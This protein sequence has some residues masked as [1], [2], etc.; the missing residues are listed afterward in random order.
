[1]EQLPMFGLEITQTGKDSRV[2]GHKQT[3]RRQDRRRTQAQ[4][5]PN[6]NYF[7]AAFRKENFTLLVKL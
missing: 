1:M 6:T 3:R 7:T 5:N 2:H 4:T